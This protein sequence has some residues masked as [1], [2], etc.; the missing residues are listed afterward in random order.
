MFHFRYVADHVDFII[1]N[2]YGITFKWLFRIQFAWFKHKVLFRNGSKGSEDDVLLLS[3][4]WERLYWICDALSG[5]FIKTL[6]SLLKIIQS[7]IILLLL[8]GLHNKPDSQLPRDIG[9]SDRNNGGVTVEDILVDDN[10]VRKTE[11][12]SHIVREGASRYNNGAWS[13]DFLYV[14]S[15]LGNI[16]VLFGVIG[17]LS[18]L[19]DLIFDGWIV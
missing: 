6:H 10:I 18:K 15:I 19:G 14:Y 4:G 5:N 16:L 17:E 9:Q 3:V 7:L 12:L 13:P 8:V 2:C 11:L 1:H